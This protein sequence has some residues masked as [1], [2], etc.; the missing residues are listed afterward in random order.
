[1]LAEFWLQTIVPGLNGRPGCFEKVEA[2]CVEIPASRHAGHG[3]AVVVVKYNAAFGQ[4]VDVGGLYPGVVVVGVEVVAVEGVE[5][6]EDG[7]H[8]VSPYWKNLK[9]WLRG[10]P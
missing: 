3:A 6:D 10:R 4:A 9:I 7:A 5:H 2:A 1:M 8:R